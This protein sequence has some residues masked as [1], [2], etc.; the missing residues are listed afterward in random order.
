MF[1]RNGGGGRWT[2]HSS[3][4]KCRCTP[5]GDSPFPQPVSRPH[6]I[7]G[8]NNRERL[9]HPIYYDRPASDEPPRG[10]KSGLY[11]TP[12]AGILLPVV[13]QHTYG[14]LSQEQYH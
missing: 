4:D 10:C 9:R 3:H 5:F 12:T 6:V 14:L 13:A 8:R 11:P 7:Q 2:T 1:A